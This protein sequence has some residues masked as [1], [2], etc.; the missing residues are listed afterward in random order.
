MEAQIVLIP[1]DI[2]NGRGGWIHL[3]VCVHHYFDWSNN[4][5]AFWELCFHESAGH[6]IELYCQR[7]EIEN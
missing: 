1:I 3:T 7:C 4:A 2:D 6:N 5:D